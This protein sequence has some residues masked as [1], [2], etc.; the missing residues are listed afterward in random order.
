MNVRQVLEYA[1]KHRVQMVDLKFVDLP[2]VWQHFT[3]PVSE[4]SEGLFKDGSG[5][6]GSS[7]RGWKAVNNSDLLVVPDPATACMDPFTAATAIEMSEATM[8]AM[9]TYCVLIARSALL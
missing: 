9:M 8:M 2:G 1:K 5:L 4:L 7:I 3:I 6:D